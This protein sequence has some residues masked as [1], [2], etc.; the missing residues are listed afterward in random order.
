MAPRNTA[1]K[2]QAPQA[3]RSMKKE[4]AEQI[5]KDGVKTKEVKK[6]TK[7]SVMAGY[8]GMAPKSMAFYTPAAVKEVLPKDDWP[9]FKY[10]PLTNT[11]N[12]ELLDFMEEYNLLDDVDFDSKDKEKITEQILNKSKKS[13]GIFLKSYKLS[14]WTVE[15]CL[16]GWV[17]FRGQDGEEIKFETDK[18]GH[19]TSECL[20]RL[21]VALVRDLHTAISTQATLTEEERTSLGL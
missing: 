4:V 11:D 9:V 21:P 1:K 20:E 18:D 7:E 15:R 10:K 17:N 12:I 8:F 13:K 14:L 6:P 2:T 16:K 5:K 19:I 3:K